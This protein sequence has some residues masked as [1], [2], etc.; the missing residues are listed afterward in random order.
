MA[1]RGFLCALPSP[2][3]QQVRFGF[4][5][6][7]PLFRAE[8]ESQTASFP[9]WRTHTHTIPPLPI[10]PLFGILISF[11]SLSLSSPPRALAG[12]GG[13]RKTITSL[14]ILERRRKEREKEERERGFWKARRLSKAFSRK[15]GGIN[16]GKRI[17]GDFWWGKGK[18]LQQSGKRCLSTVR[19]T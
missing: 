3:F 10:Q 11:P 6:F 14:P 18:R 5:F 17:K 16:G 19:G 7:L 4:A 9:A 8:R 13:G 12:K 1:E 15:K 2:L